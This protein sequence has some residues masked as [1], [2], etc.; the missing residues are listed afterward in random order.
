MC[1]EFV[2]ALHEAAKEDHVNVVM[3]TGA[4][5]FF[6]S[7]LDYS[8]LIDCHCPLKSQAKLLVEKYK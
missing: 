8:Q 7:G 1:E 4:G 6:C 2:S 5:E 3:V